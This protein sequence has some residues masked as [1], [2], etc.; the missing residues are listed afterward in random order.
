MTVANQAKYSGSNFTAALMP[1]S[2]VNYTDHS[3]VAMAAATSGA[4]WQPSQT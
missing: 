2:T 3:D 4:G 1:V